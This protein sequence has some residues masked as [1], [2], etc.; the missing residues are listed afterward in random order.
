MKYLFLLILIFSCQSKISKQNTNSGGIKVDVF[1]LTDIW[2]DILNKDVPADQQFKVIE[3]GGAGDC[4]FY[5][6]ATALSSYS[7]RDYFGLTA[8]K[9]RE[10]LAETITA[11]NFVLT[12]NQIRDGIHPDLAADIDLTEVLTN[13]TAEPKGAAL[14]QEVIKAMASQGGYNFTSLQGGEPQD[15]SLSYWGDLYA[16]KE[17]SEKYELIR[18]M[19][20]KHDEPSFG[21]AVSHSACVL[22]NKPEIESKK[23]LNIILWWTG[24][25]YQLVGK[26][27]A[28][29]QS[30]I[31]IDSLNYKILFENDELPVSLKTLYSTQCRWE[32]P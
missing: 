26:K 20:L 1:D 2:N 25:H 7:G 17:L 27:T 23:F 6:V 13:A 28:N 19:V 4:F 18:F 3:T 22:K 9:V 10:D 30:S 11:E 14:L 32:I 29:P 24:G 31:K 15:F 5:S 12:S 16:L 8:N 21:E